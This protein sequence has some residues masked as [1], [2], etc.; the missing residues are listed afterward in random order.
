MNELS[1][2]EWLK[3]NDIVADIYNIP[4]ISAMRAK[5][6]E[7]VQLLIPFQ[8]AF[9]DLCSE[10]GSKRSFF[11]PVAI[12]I[13][14]ETLTEYYQK[15]ETLDYTVWAISQNIALSYRDT[16]ILPQELRVNSVFFTG[17]LQPMGIFYEGGCNIVHGGLLYGSIT[18]MRD[19]KSGDFT[20]TELEILNILNRHLCLRFYREYPNGIDKKAFSP[21]YSSIMSRYRLT[22]RE[23]EILGLIKEGL[24][25]KEISEK[26]YISENT[27]KKHIGHIFKKLDITS[28][29]QIFNFY[30]DEK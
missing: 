21:L 23:C 29:T 17:W 14:E 3:I 24:P 18:L 30:P 19:K 15:F 1:H 28:R 11:N 26:L 8:R 16:D 22:Q 7:K 5:Y 25:N 9:F 10:K 12:N 2:E 27:T 20:D 6:L 4:D 13:E